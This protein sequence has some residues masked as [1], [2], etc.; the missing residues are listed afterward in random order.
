MQMA[1]VGLIHGY[2]FLGERQEA[3]KYYTE[4]RRKFPHPKGIFSKEARLQREK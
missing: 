1:Y 3:T 2:S 4:Y